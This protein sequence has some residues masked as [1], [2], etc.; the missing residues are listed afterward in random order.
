MSIFQHYTIDLMDAKVTE[1]RLNR[2]GRSTGQMFTL[3]VCSKQTTVS[4]KTPSHR[5][6]IVYGVART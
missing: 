3:G 4:F 6:Q 2:R 1:K 5:N